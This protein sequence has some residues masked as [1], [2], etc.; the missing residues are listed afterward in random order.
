VNNRT[1]DIGSLHAHTIETEQM[2]ALMLDEMTARL[3]AK[4][5]ASS[6]KL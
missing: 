6:E 4:V 3:K 5:E 2:M 1:E